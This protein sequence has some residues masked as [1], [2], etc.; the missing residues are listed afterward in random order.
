M[1]LESGKKPI[2]KNINY[3]KSLRSRGAIRVPVRVNKAP[4]Y[5]E[6]N[7]RTLSI[8]QLAT[9][10]WA[11]FRCANDPEIGYLD[12]HLSLTEFLD[13]RLGRSIKIK[14]EDLQRLLW[15]GNQADKHGFFWSPNNKTFDEFVA[16]LIWPGEVFDKYINLLVKENEAKNIKNKLRFVKRFKRKRKQRK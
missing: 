8:G 10:L 7:M 15:A 11:L 5:H 14:K 13:N 6:E 4:G 12:A 2:N 1:P 3:F 9:L 16:P